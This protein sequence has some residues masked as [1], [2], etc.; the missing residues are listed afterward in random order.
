M[1]LKELLGIKNVLRGPSPFKMSLGDEF[2]YGKRRY[3][4]RL[5]YEDLINAESELGRTIFGPVPVG[6]Q[7]EFFKN[8]ENVWIWY[9]KWT[10]AAGTP[11][12]VTIRYEIRPNGVYKKLVDKN[13]EKIEGDELNNFVSA[14]RSY[15]KLVKDKLY[16]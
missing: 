8:K 13:Y 11:Q 5:T 15:Y 14:V 2:L 10:D 9:E 3:G 16:N 12:D 4:G 6:H 1:S 7:R